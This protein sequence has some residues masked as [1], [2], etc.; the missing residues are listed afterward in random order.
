MCA[1]HR[2]IPKFSHENVTFEVCF[3][4]LSEIVLRQRQSGS[5]LVLKL[6]SQKVSLLF[7]KNEIRFNHISV[8]GELKFLNKTSLS[9]R[10]LRCR[11]TGHQYPLRLV[12]QRNLWLPCS[13][14][15]SC[16]KSMYASVTGNVSN[17]TM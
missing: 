13:A 17:I 5:L 4:C 14:T 9:Y 7:M 6:L 11:P 3:R 10:S 16:G 12:N 8:K 15:E 1:Q 2:G